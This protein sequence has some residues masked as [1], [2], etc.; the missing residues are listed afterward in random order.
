MP[1]YALSHIPYKIMYMYQPTVPWR[2]EILL[3]LFTFVYV[4]KKKNVICKAK[5]GEEEK[6]IKQN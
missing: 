3:Y 4:E 6:A 2:K 5:Q 1:I